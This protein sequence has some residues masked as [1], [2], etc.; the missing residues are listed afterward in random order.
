MNSIE[1]ITKYPDYL[2]LIKKV[3]KEEYQ[4]ILTRMEEWDP[5]DLI[6]PESWFAD[7]NSAIGFVYRLFIREVKNM[8]G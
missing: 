3:T 6:T 2:E 1:F 4:P 7:E 5:H 8:E